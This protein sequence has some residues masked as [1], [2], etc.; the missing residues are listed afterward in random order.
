MPSKNMPLSAITPRSTWPIEVH[1]A[2]GR[3]GGSTFTPKPS[4]RPRNQRRGPGQPLVA[5]W[6]R[7]D[8][9]LY[10]YIKE[11]RDQ[12]LMH[13]LQA[14]D[15]LKDGVDDPTTLAALRKEATRLANKRRTNALERLVIMG[16][17]RVE[18]ALQAQADAGE[19]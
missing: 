18:A 3:D 5:K 10:Q 19:E 11:Y 6:K 2:L 13:L 7:Y 15:W 9:P 14:C 8:M 17:L 16:Y 12:R 1:Q 4:S